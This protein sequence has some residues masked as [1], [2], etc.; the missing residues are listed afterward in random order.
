MKEKQIIEKLNLLTIMEIKE[1]Y[2]KSEYERICC[3]D[4]EKVKQIKEEIKK[5]LEEDYNTEDY[6]IRI[7]CNHVSI[8]KI[9]HR[10]DNSTGLT[11]F[12]K[13]YS[14]NFKKLPYAYAMG[15]KIS[16]KAMENFISSCEGGE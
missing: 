13:I 14:N 6:Y 10:D 3:K 2:N 1:N 12:K 7:S 8:D 9:T 15:R 5:M 11:E 4:T 16:K